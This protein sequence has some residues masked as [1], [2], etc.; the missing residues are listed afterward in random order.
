MLQ[1]RGMSGPGIGNGWV[2]EQGEG[3]WDRVFFGG[4]MKKG[5]QI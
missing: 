2:S 5:N 1:C 4:E 3:G